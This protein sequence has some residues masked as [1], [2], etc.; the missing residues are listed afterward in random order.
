M[1]TKC[2]KCGAYLSIYNRGEICWHH[3][4]YPVE[5][6]W[7][8]LDGKRDKRGNPVGFTEEI[9]YNLPSHWPMVA[10]EWEIMYYK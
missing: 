6:K 3:E 10:C 2:K 7:F 1:K 5:F 8:K 4:E 9:V